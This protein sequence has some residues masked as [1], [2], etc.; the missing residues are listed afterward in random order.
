MGLRTVGHGFGG[1]GRQMVK[2]VT[3]GRGKLYTKL[4][5]GAHRIILANFRAG[6]KPSWLVSKA[7]AAEGRPTL[8][9]KGN[10]FRSITRRGTASQAEVTTTDHRAAI[11]HFGGII[12]PKKAEYLTIPIAPEAKGKRTSDFPQDETWFHRT[13]E[14]KLFLMWGN[15]SLFLLVKKV[16]MPARPFMD[17]PPDDIGELNAIVRDH[18]LDVTLRVQ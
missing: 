14:G 18:M 9:A 7:A 10:L 11:H 4:A 15:K 13:D 3:Q 8:I 1:V 17:I 12:V 16:A 6:G 5:A 2:P